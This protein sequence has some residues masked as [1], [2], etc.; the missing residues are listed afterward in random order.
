MS[1]RQTLATW[2]PLCAV[3]MRK[4]QRNREGNNLKSDSA[5]VLSG[6]SV[7]FGKMGGVMKL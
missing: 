5:E 2:H 1:L 3:G 7:K 6:L 4:N